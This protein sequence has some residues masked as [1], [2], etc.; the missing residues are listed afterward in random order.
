MDIEA[1]VSKYF[2]WCPGIKSASKFIPSTNLSIKRKGFR[3]HHVCLAMLIII[4]TFNA[5]FIS[6]TQNFID[7]FFSIYAVSLFAA[8]GQSPKIRFGI[9]PIILGAI[10][11]GASLIV[12]RSVAKPEK[13]FFI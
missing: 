2:G 13:E 5:V 6:Q 12:N 11:T 3:A 1:L 4:I 9:L 7:T 8:R 10:I